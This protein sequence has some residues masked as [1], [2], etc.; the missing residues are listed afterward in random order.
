MQP[1]PLAAPAGRPARGM[2]IIKG[3]K[4][5][6]SFTQAD[7]DN[8]QATILR[9]GQPIQISELRTGDRL[10]ATII[11]QR[12]PQ[13]LTDRQVKATISDVARMET[14]A[15]GAGGGA[16]PAR[17]A[18]T[19]PARQLPKTASPVPLMGLIAGVA[20]FVAGS[21]RAGRRFIG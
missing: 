6:Q 7:V 12:P 21:R 4:G 3:P 2:I 18:V 19:S 15:A 11:T 8:R 5:F 16:A 13:V 1:V 20:F 9:D 10:T 17:A 14:P